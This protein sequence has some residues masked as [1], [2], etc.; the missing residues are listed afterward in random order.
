M[1]VPFRFWRAN[2]R[3]VGRKAA[4]MRHVCMDVSSPSGRD[5]SAPCASVYLFI[6]VAFNLQHIKRPIKA[7]KLNNKFNGPI[8][9]THNNR[10]CGLFASTAN[11]DGDAR[12]SRRKMRDH[13]PVRMHVIFRSIRRANTDSS[14]SD[15]WTSDS[16]ALQRTQKKQMAVAANARR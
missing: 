5:L 12:T 2:R 1:C 7:I 11:G 8:R 4:P 6:L 14:C 10:R 9:N 16:S 3:R 15:E 13:V